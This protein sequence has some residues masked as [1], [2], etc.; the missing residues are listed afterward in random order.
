[1]SMIRKN[2]F[3]EDYLMFSTMK[4]YKNP[5]LPSPIPNWSNFAFQTLLIE[6]VV[7]FL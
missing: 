5:Y 3:S 2:Y 4:V 7:P 6:K 1:M